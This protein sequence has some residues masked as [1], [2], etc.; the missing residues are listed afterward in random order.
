MLDLNARVGLDE[1]VAVL[2]ID[3]ELEGARAL[4][5]HRFGQAHRVGG[6]SIANVRVEAAGG[7]N[8][9]DLLVTSLH[10][11]V[12][13]EQ[14]HD[15][16]FLVAEDLHLDVTRTLDE[17]L[18]EHGAV[19]ERGLGLGGRPEERVLELVGAANHSHA[20]TTTA[21]GGL[22]HQREADF[23]GESPGVFDVGYRVGRTG[24]DRDLGGLGHAT[25]LGLVTEVAQ[26]LGRRSHEHDARV[27]AGLS[28]VGVLRQEPVAGVNGIDTVFERDLDDLGDPQ[29]RTD[30]GLALP[31]EIGLVGLV[32]VKMQ[33]IFVTEDGHRSDPEFGCGPKHT[34]RNFSSVGAE[35][36]LDGSRRRDVGH[37]GEA[38]SC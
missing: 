38:A 17:A 14:V 25:P 30:G 6:E 9:D 11:A 18:D 15:V 4:V 27:G 36:L 28:Q 10:R 35:D 20:A 3:E 19:T 32:A 34:D 5:A 8:L 12:A 24:N 29:V 22:D 7:R 23:F 31:D 16:A 26:H 2:L 21:L 33:T 37:G 13:L 1:V